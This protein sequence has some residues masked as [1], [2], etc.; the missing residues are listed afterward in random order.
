MLE[1]IKHYYLLIKFNLSHILNYFK[2]KVKLCLMFVRLFRQEFW[3]LYFTKK[4][5]KIRVNIFLNDKSCFLLS[6]NVKSVYRKIC[7]KKKK[8]DLKVYYTKKLYIKKQSYLLHY[9]LILRY[10]L[11][12][13][14]SQ[15]TFSLREINWHGVSL[16][17]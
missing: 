2:T 5:L 11:E 16:T 9:W 12:E 3:A 8:V 10:L 6:S 13:L 4:W 17:C 1:L 14:I 7:N 15:P